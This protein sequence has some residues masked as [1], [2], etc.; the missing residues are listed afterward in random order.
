[1]VQN[2][3]YK[4]EENAHDPFLRRTINKVNDII[5]LISIY[6]DNLVVVSNTLKRL[7][8]EVKM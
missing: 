7:K 1:M 2:V 8:R 6:I 3:G 5:T 4:V